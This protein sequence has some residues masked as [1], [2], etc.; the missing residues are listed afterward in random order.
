[1][2]VDSAHEHSE[3][4]E[5]GHFCWCCSLPGFA[6]GQ[7]RFQQKLLVPWFLSWLTSVIE[8][9]VSLLWWHCHF[10]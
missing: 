2:M 6:D 3:F 9:T 5:A 10:A 7:Y 1:M 8:V 4:F